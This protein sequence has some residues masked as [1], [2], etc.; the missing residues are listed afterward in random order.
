VIYFIQNERT[1]NIKIGSA[2][3]VRTRLADLQTGS[4]D[5][6]RLIGVIPG[7]TSD[8]KR[9]QRLFGKF[10]F[11]GEWFR[12]NAVVM[13]FITK[14]ARDEIEP[15][16]PTPV[17]RMRQ[18]VK[19]SKNRLAPTYR[20]HKAS[21]QAVVTLNGRDVYLGQFESP[22]SYIRYEQV[23]ADWLTRGRQL[24]VAG[25]E[26]LMKEVVLGYWSDRTPRLPQVEIDKLRLALRWVRELYGELPAV[27][28]TP[29]RFKAIRQRMI[30]TGNS[31]NYIKAQLGVIKKMI[32]WAVENELIPGEVLHR[33][34]AVAPPDV[35]ADGIKPEKIIEP[36]S[37]EHLRAVLPHVGPPIRAMI[38]LQRCTGMRPGEV[39]RLTM[40]QID[41]STDPWIYRPTQH[42][43]MRH[44]IK[45]AIP[46]TKRAQAVLLPWLKAD[47]DA[48]LFSPQA[49]YERAC[50]ESR[51]PQPPHARRKRPRT[52]KFKPVYSAA[53]YR[54]AIYRGCDRAGIPRFHPNQI[55]HTVAEQV[56][57]EGGIDL[58]QALLGHTR[59]RMTERY[60]RQSLEK[61]ELAK[62]IE[63]AKR[64]G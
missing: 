15:G 55:R 12:P 52:R 44:G 37:D 64:I 4:C 31:I 6:L 24:P 25:G 39:A 32:A 30:D 29:M 35:V 41:R 46:L 11:R 21:G 43:T 22:E 16:S 57:T 34:Q 23:V 3:D 17:P 53:A 40:A 59:S 51:R 62:A 54:T 2:V 14:H 49:E 18:A 5:P 1:A 36:V 58:A 50:E 60:A 45:R 10:R 7:D 13:A 9:L 48:P 28:F 61:A 47:P 8:E 20:K 33:I 38:E 63:A 26:L 56:T 42:K 19:P 27:E